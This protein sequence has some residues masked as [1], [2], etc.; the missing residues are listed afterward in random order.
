M[1]DDVFRRIAGEDAAVGTRDVDGDT[2]FS[3]RRIVID[4]G[5]EILADA[6]VERE[7]GDGQKEDGE[8]KPVSERKT[9]LTTS[10]K[11]RCLNGKSRS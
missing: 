9:T 8:N 5:A 7:G 10:T 1:V 3:S 11:E 2:G 6:V 4:E